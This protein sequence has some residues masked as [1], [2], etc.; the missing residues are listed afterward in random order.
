MAIKLGTAIGGHFLG[1]KLSGPSGAQK[2]AMAGTQSAA[3]QLS[4]AAPGFLK[5][6]QQ[7]T[8]Q[9]G[10]TLGAAGDY[11]RNI[12]SNRGAARE[13]LAPEMSTALDFYRGAERKTEREMRG[14]SKD[15]A[16]AEL[17]RQK[18]GQLAGMLPAA[19]RSAAEGAAG[20]GGTFLGYGGQ[21]AG[22]GAN[23]LGQSLGGQNMLFNQAGAIQQ[24]Q[25]EGGD[26]MGR[27]IFDIL[28][29]GM[30]KFGGGKRSPTVNRSEGTAAYGYRPPSPQ[31]LL[32]R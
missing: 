6:G 22:M 19:R 4:Q 28:N 12:L 32:P 24:Q 17:Q 21:Q 9:G 16:L 11:Y 18:V 7:F 13:S 14:G 15:Y 23:L 27:F 10:Q 25:Q 29:S 20:V 30:G 5:Q 3:G 1:K 2:S 8:Q 26:V 31:L